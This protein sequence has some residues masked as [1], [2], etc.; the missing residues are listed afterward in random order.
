MKVVFGVM[1]A[2]CASVV[3]LAGSSNP[4]EAE[5][6]CTYRAGGRCYVYSACVICGVKQA[7]HDKGL[8]LRFSLLAALS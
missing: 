6:I 8:A 7:L 1:G 4:A 3:I 2:A 5:P